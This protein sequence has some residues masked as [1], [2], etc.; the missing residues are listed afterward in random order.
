MLR[1]AS[2]DHGPVHRVD[3]ERKRRRAP[4]DA[5]ERRLPSNKAG[6][7]ATIIGIV[8]LLISGENLS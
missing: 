4:I 7:I 5:A 2:G 6:T 3:G 1:N 8:T